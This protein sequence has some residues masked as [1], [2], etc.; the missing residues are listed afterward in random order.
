MGEEQGEMTS[1]DA[2]TTPEYSSGSNTILGK[3]CGLQSQTN[4]DTIPSSDTSHQCDYQNL[5]HTV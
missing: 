5:W 2:A 4:I 3:E 1:Y